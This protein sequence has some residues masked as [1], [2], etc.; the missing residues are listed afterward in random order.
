MYVYC[1]VSDEEQVR[2]TTDLAVEKYGKLDIMYNNAGVINFATTSILII[3]KSDF[4]KVLGINL[5]GGILGAK[6]ATRVMVSAKKGCILLTTSASTSLAW[7]I[8]YGDVTSN[9][10]R[11]ALKGKPIS[12]TPVEGIAA[13]KAD[14]DE[15]DRE[16]LD[17]RDASGIRF[18]LTKNILGLSEEKAA[19]AKEDFYCMWRFH[20]VVLAGEQCW[21]CLRI[22]AEDKVVET[23]EGSGVT[24]WQFCHFLGRLAIKIVEVPEQIFSLLDYDADLPVSEYKFKCLD[25]MGRELEWDCRF[26]EELFWDVIVGVVAQKEAVKLIAEEEIKLEDVKIV[27]GILISYG[28]SGKVR[29]HESMSH[30]EHEEVIGRFGEFCKAK[31]LIGARW[32]NFIEHAGRQFKSCVVGFGKEHFYLLV[33]LEKEKLDR[34]LDESISLEYYYRDIQGDLDKGF[35]WYLSQLEYGLCLHPS[36][37]AKGIMNII[38]ACPVQLNGNIWEVK[39]VSP[40]SKMGR[41]KSL[42][43]TVAQEGVEVGDVLKKLSISMKKWVNSRYEKVQKSQA[44]RLMMGVGGNKKRGANGK[45]RAV[46]PKAYGVDFADVPKV[47]TS[48][49][50][51]R[52]FPKKKMLKRGSTSTTIRSSEGEGA[53]KKRR[54]DLS[55]LIGAKVAEDRSSE[56]DKLKSVEDK[57][58]LAA[59]RGEEEM[60][61]RAARLI[62]G[63]FLG[64]EEE[65]AVLD[66]GKIKLEKKVARLKIDLAWDG[67]WLESV[68][69]GQEVR[70][71]D[72][73]EETR[74]NLGELV[75]QRD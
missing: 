32:G 59:R 17:S 2:N 75:V 21:W 22:L 50:L 42:L 46:L 69:G 39:K 5:I 56:V 3:E 57:V 49:K 45:R 4:K 1:D 14:D 33:D 73:V 15:E 41:K 30:H 12:K 63:I 11:K 43:D 48:S 54:I 25:W 8:F 67:K 53:A 60:T 72:L 64:M 35:L 36:N 23:Y 47:T 51:A 71:S 19:E 52:S 10:L 27:E 40:S 44:T 34:D 31:V 18:F 61:K 58:R 38:R 37:L 24:S 16:D 62:K 28:S 7:T 66:R 70:I 13:Q 9:G 55:E 65:E 26:Y 74:N 20:H 68:K 6:H 29:L